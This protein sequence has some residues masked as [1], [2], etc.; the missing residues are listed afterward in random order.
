MRA[1][2]LLIQ[3]LEPRI[4]FDAAI[5]ATAAEAT[6]H[7]PAADHANAPT[8]VSA[9]LA[10]RLLPV[11]RDANPP[12]AAPAG[13]AKEVVFV[14]ADLADA[15]ALVSG[16][17]PG[18]DVVML[19]RA[20]DGLAQMANYL[21]GKQGL[22]AI[23]LISHG[24]EGVVE[25]GNVWLDSQNL[26]AHRAVL[27]QIGASLAA[28]GDI[29]LYGCKAGAGPAG[30]ALLDGLARLT[31]ADVAASEDDTGAASH[32]GDWQLERQAGTVESAALR[33]DS[34]A[35]LLAVPSD[36]NY[37]TNS[38]ASF[39]ADTFTLDNIKY[40][41]VG[42]N[43]GNYTNIVSNNSAMSLLGNNA[44]DYFMFF[45]LAGAFGI[46]SIKVEA[47]DGS[48]FRLSNIS[49]DAAADVNITI[50]P[51]GGTALTYSSNGA[52]ILQQNVN[53][54]GNVNFQ[55]I[56]SFTI[57]G[58]NLSLALDDLDFEA[59]V[60]A[61]AV[62][63][64]SATGG[65][66]TFTEGGS[67][68]DLYS[69]VTAATNDAG[70]TF[71]GMTMTVTNVGNDSS[72]ILTIG[73][74]DVALNNGNSGT[75]TG[76]GSYSV[77]VSGSTA[78]VTVTGMTRTDAQMG[79]LVDGM[80]YRNTSQDPST[81]NR[82]VTITGITDS[83]GSNNTANPA[84]V[85]TVT[86]VAV[87]D[88]PTLTATGGT[89]T[90]T[91]N[92]SAVDLFSG[93]SISTVESGQTI[94]RLILTVTN[95]SDGANEI[96]TID[97]TTV[98]LTNGNSVTTG[99]NS[100]SVSVSLAAGTATVTISKAAGVS[101]AI[102]QTVV[103]GI[104]YSNSSESPGTTSRVITLTNI[105]DNGGT[106]NS[107]VD[108]TTLAVAAT[109]AVSAVND[110]P[111]LTGG[112]HAMTG[113]DEDTT[114]GGT[115]VSAILA[116]GGYADVDT[117]AVSGMAVTTVSG[118]GTWQYS[119]D[120]NTWTAFG[121]VSAASSLLLS[122]T[123]QV[124]YVPDAQNAET[125]TFTF[126]AWDQTSGTAS[127]NGT[128]QSG[129]SGTTGTTTAY[130]SS[131]A[132]V[133]IAVSAVNDAPV[134]TA[135]SPT[136]TGINE[137]A[138]SNAG[139]TVASFL[140]ASVADVDSGALSGIAI[141]GVVAG[142]GTW[143]YSL[144]GSTWSNIGTVSASSALLL[145]SGDF[146]RLV[147]DGQNGTSASLTYRA[148]DQTG[149]SAGQQ[150]TKL[151]SSVN[152]GTTAYSSVTDTA[153]I[154]VSSVNDAPTLSGGPYS[155]TGTDEDTVSGAV[156]VATLLAGM[157]YADVDSAAVSGIAVITTSAL[158]NWQYS[159]DGS[160]WTAFGAVSAN[161]ALLLAS[162]TQVR[163]L[164][165]TIHGETATFTF[166]GWDQTTGTASSNGATQ[167]GD[168]TSN[169]GSTA[170][171]SGTAQGSIVV[172][173]INEAPAAT[174][175]GGSA[176]FTE[177]NNVAGTPVVVDAGITVA[178]N[179]SAT[180]ASALVS[181]SGNFAS[182][183]DVLAFTNDGITMGNISG[184]YSAGVLTL[185][186]SGATATLAEWQAAL[187]VVS[188][189]NSSDSPSTA[190]RT[191]GFVLNDGT[192]S[193][194]AATRTVTV[195]SVDDTP[196]ATASGGTTAFAEGNNTTSTPVAVD[197]GLSLS[198]LDST[199]LA[200]AT[201][202]ITGNFQS[203]E[204]VLA[205]TNSNATTFGNISASYSTGVL[206]LTSSGATATVAQ[207]QAALRAV[208]YTNDVAQPNTATRTISFEVSD[209]N[210]NSAVV[211][212]LVSVASV[213]DAPQI[214]APATLSVTEDTASVLTGISFSDTDA[215]GAT[216]TV[217]LAVGTGTLSGISSGGVT[218]S[219]GGTATLTLSG[220][221][222]DINAYI[223]GSAVSFLTA[224]SATADVTL[225]TTID[226]G[227]NTGSGGTQ[228]DSASTT[229]NV[230]QVNDAPTITAPASIAVNEDVA[231]SMA[232]ISF[233]DIDA[234]SGAVSVTLSVASGTLS[235]T[236]GSGVTV[237]GSNSG[238]L[239]LSGSVADINSFI[240]AN[241]VLFRTAS[242]ATANVTLSVAIDDGGN[243]GTD[244]GGSGTGGS[245]AASTTLNLL[246]S[247]VND[248][249]VN[250]APATQSTPKDVDLL[251]N[252]GNGNLISVSDA[253]A[254][255][256]LVTLTASNG[257]ITLS[258]TTGLTMLTGSGS[259][260]LS[261]SFEG[262]VADINAALNGLRFIP[263][264]GY[265]GS[266]SLQIVSNDQGFSGSGG[267]QT[268]TDT[269]NI[270][271]A[272]PNP[273]IT[274]VHAVNPDGGYK[275][276]DT[277]QI[278]LSLDQVVTVSGG[279][280]TLLLETGGVD[281][282]ASYVSGSGSN[283]L[284][285]SYTVQAG[286]LSADLDYQSTAALVLNGATVRNGSSDDLLLLLP[287]TGGSGSIAGQHAIVV[288]G[289]APVVA[290]LAAPAD[291]TYQT[292]DNLDFTVNFSEAVVVDTTGGTPR[293]AV[294]LDTG[295]TVYA[296]YVSGSGSGALVFRLTVA[297]GQAD[298][299]G[300]SLAGSLDLNGG[301][302]RDTVGNAVVTTL[303]GVASTAGVLIDA[304]LPTVAN[305]SVP[306]A[307]HYQ[308]GEVLSFTV[309]TSEAVTVNTGG[310]TP[311]LAITVGG[312][313][314]YANYVSGSG[315]GALLF[316]YT[317][318]AGHNDSDGIALAG[319]IDLNG[320]AIADGV[321][322]N[323]AT[324]LNSPGDTSAVLV[325][326]TM[327]TP[328]GIVRVGSS[329][330]GADS[331]SYTVTFSEGVSG[332]DTA[333]FGLV[334]GGS[335]GGTIGSVTQ[336]DD[337]T[338]TVTITGVTG[339][340]DIRLDLNGSGTGITDLAGNAISGG[341]TGEVFAVDRDAPSVNSVV[342]PA[343]GIYAT[344]Q[345]LDFTVNY[346]KAV[347]VDGGIP[348][349]AITLDNGDTVFASY[350]SG[351]GG[352][353]L[354]FRLTVASG[355]FDGNG[356]AVASSLDLNGATLRDG[357]GN[358]AALTLNGMDSSAGVRIDA[359]APT[360][361][362]IVQIRGGA[363]LAFTVSFNEDVSGVDVGDFQLASTG[364]A[365]GSIASVTRIDG[366]N[367]T[368]QVNGLAG[369]GTLGLTLRASGSGIAD[370]AG[371]LLVADFSGSGVPVDRA[372]P[373]ITGVTV[374]ANG[375]YKGEQILDFS[376]NLSKATLVDTT[377]GT[378]RLAI[379][380]GDR[381]VF[382]SYVSGSGGS[383]LL[384]RYTVQAGDNDADG[385]A[386]TGLQANGA[387]LRD[388]NG[389]AADLGLRGLPSTA[390]ILID[391][392]PPAGTGI[393]RLDATPTS[394]TSARYTVTFSENVQGLDT[395]AFS[396]SRLGLVSGEIGTVT[397][398]DARTYTVTLT[399]LRGAGLISLNLRSNAAVT[400]T[401][402]NT[403]AG[404]MAGEVYIVSPIPLPPIVLPP[405]VI[406]PVLPPPFATPPIIGANPI[407]L[408]PIIPNIVLTALDSAPLSNPLAPVDGVSGV[409]GHELGAD[410][411]GQLGFQLAG[412]GRSSGPGDGRPTT[413]A[414]SEAPFIATADPSQRDALVARPDLGV[415]NLQPGQNFGFALPAGTFSPREPDSRISITVRLANGR[416]LPNWLRFDSLNGWFSG[417]VPDNQRQSL[418]LEIIVRDGNGNQAI[419]R[420]EIEFD[421]QGAAGAAKQAMLERVGKPDL[422]SQF[423]R[424]GQAA[425][426]RERDLLLGQQA[427]KADVLV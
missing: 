320:G 80:T 62:P 241:S 317:V 191:I 155:F 356:I 345:T 427:A 274:S 379:L 214:T 425:F 362:G 253:E 170:Y 122:S 423:E 115:L 283:T 164:P 82:V 301:T 230:A 302:L 38:G 303:N 205:F 254:S 293:I 407:D 119:T 399:G 33:V 8:D 148:W 361:T 11:S 228:T 172:S 348:R 95:V 305:V 398:V 193:G 339:T 309:N 157:S 204:D 195:A 159:T 36:E 333:D 259:N 225:T 314:V 388:A 367:Y 402:G 97:G 113:I 261:M 206:T 335:A 377:G 152:G 295:G 351:S 227:G 392:A 403:L 58:G 13:P 337:Q 24:A 66:P 234:G 255:T 334:F 185:T 85:A 18:V 163:Y 395:S 47:A 87:N 130:S 246:V 412:Q 244:P 374:P 413:L 156:T 266:A 192:D 136:L 72:E 161:S 169:G 76:I 32:G 151:D 7:L 316:Q 218:A 281:R 349:I 239:G 200:G 421:K 384:F 101:T 387:I 60:S 267:N 419:S 77:A 20:G 315:T 88:A 110:A 69:A 396:L 92:G 23:H 282:L 236:S 364:T 26:A 125:A 52:L 273:L 166:R 45:D 286:D 326:T 139:Q 216:V 271:V 306:A 41:I 312:A 79:T 405:I 65:T 129:N 78:T 366:R 6:H 350:V 224:G 406:P 369:S 223:A 220:T 176:A 371:N 106:A 380:L 260:D 359:R 251:F 99:S 375:A 238:S 73:G 190:V 328:A 10:E 86:V 121:S 290:T 252:A 2:P 211:T 143:Q 400:D 188:Y 278:T 127:S 340:G 242:N 304:V 29:L 409:D 30:L 120:G 131:T 250:S 35:S 116:T 50:T 357:I 55:N 149:A 98:A 90:F 353:A 5:A 135:A 109:V 332:V 318:L 145:R 54:S 158:G 162:T 249:P 153:S 378:P 107:G 108:A 212:K 53:T 4:M 51:N 180:L 285:F 215:G 258:G 294:T 175:S 287:A 319:S 178:D 404:P 226:D 382:A 383:T 177:G 14:A 272:L 93:V 325:D 210:T 408:G 358:N 393:V 376:V 46:S 61:S 144:D 196:V 56:T 17:K 298:G 104:T 240:A 343:N 322:N 150:G 167:H 310:G 74:T 94:D 1:K 414:V 263:T 311:R 40:T 3:A 112:T 354:T 179:D 89:P 154:T 201:V 59:P 416:P 138:T 231:T 12:A 269:I 117:G 199:T 118:N 296:S 415:R 126:R 128:P 198:D 329:P 321:G 28:D 42:S 96:L 280:P 134:L 308:A 39:T 197:T 165:D 181:I 245:E 141:S 25:V 397:Q 48:A 355:Q 360:A 389:T 15:Q 114:S 147:P 331:I 43:P 344:G 44:G 257:L 426:E 183:E 299:N 284:T 422:A 368:V 363:G 111:T 100:L 424:Y 133:S 9:R 49:F 330:S 31:G 411:A 219:G 174:T 300:V 140:G 63:T 102:A 292:G 262:S 105:R 243:T 21:Q 289:V 373:A 233:T 16:L 146:V 64:L 217:T 370:S 67:T 189:S 323:L 256:L 386:I 19:D 279:V 81:S 324:A 394:A 84:R 341:L 342:L 187:R 75:L 237:T 365:A 202:S 213:N 123:T 70:Q 381:T 352:T 390:G 291:G 208:T 194:S 137:D 229:L 346:S 264:P 160:T 417:Q 91:E 297:A 207:W 418:E 171:S 275:V 222:A 313:T 173:P 124:R 57:A 142:T 420:M 347:L 34:Y 385:I 277:I 168:S 288:D 186:S 184:S 132:T 391:T 83:G 248:A 401:A 247:A 203:G 71:S 27:G 372:G 235:A 68:V 268:D 182:G 232:G 336:I 103:D 37:D 270:T 338:Y 22:Q 307:D 276:G 265:T 410:G 209:G 221:L 327:P